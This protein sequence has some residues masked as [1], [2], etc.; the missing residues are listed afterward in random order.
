MVQTPS[1]D[2]VEHP[3]RGAG[4]GVAAA[5]GALI[6]AGVLFGLAA[7]QAGK[8]V[9]VRYDESKASAGA[10]AEKIGVA[11]DVVGVAAVVTGVLLISH[12]R[13]GRAA[14]MAN[15]RAGVTGDQRSAALVVGGTF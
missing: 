8:D 14:P 9:S 3:W 6:A 15:L 10:L 4:I 12:R 7:H 11:A 5:G 2:R 1:R 13:Q